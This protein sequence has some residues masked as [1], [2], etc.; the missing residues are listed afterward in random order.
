MLKVVSTASDAALVCEVVIAEW[1]ARPKRLLDIPSTVV[2]MARLSKLSAT[3]SEA[4]ASFVRLF[5]LACCVYQGFARRNTCNV[6][7][8]NKDACQ[9]LEK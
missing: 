8:E 7:D 2:A 3:A 4:C 5:R 9:T 1:A 6:T